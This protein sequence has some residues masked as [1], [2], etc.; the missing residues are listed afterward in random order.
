MRMT[1]TFRVVC[2]GE[3]FKFNGNMY[4]KKSTRTAKM[5]SNGKTFYIEQL[6]GCMI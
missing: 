1:V 5:L 6:A 3:L 4:Q 2:I